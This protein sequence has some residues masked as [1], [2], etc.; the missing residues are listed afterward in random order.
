MVWMWC[1]V[2][3]RAVGREGVGGVDGGSDG[4]LLVVGVGVGVDQP[5]AFSSSRNR[6]HVKSTPPPG[7][8][9]PSGSPRTARLMPW[10]ISVSL[11]QLMQ[12]LATR[13]KVFSGVPWSIIAP[14][15]PSLVEESRFPLRGVRD[16]RL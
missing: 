12:K 3:A 15:L 9:E 6:A 4:G 7:T 5:R 8:S 10:T 11:A 14:V 1:T 16:S 2:W 13:P